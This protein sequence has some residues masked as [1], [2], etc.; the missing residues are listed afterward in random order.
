MNGQVAIYARV[1][2]EKQAE[3]HTIDSQLAAVRERVAADG[4]ELLEELQF[5]DNGYSG[6]TLIRPGLERLRD[7]AA[8]GAF[9]RL[10]VHSP[11]RLARKYAYQILLVDELRRVGV[12]VVFLNHALGR[13]PEDELLLQVQGMMAEYERA[14]IMERSRRGRRHAALRGSVNALVG[15]PYGY[16]Y[17]G[18]HQG[19]GEASVEVLEDEARVVRQ[20][21]TWV[22]RDRIPLQQV[23]VRLVEA[24]IPTRSGKKW[25]RPGTVARMLRN[26]AY[27]GAAVFGKT[28]SGPQRPRLR[29]Y[30]GHPAQAR[31]PYSSYAVPEDKWIRVPVPVL[32]DTDLFTAVC[33]Q[34]QENRQRVRERREGARHLL[35]GL[36]VCM[37]C[38][39]A[40]TGSKSIHQGQ[41]YV[42]YLCAGTRSVPAGEQR[43]CDNRPVRADTLEAIVWR[44]IRDLLGDPRRLEQ[45]YL[46][47]LQSSDRVL[48]GHDPTRLDAQ[49]KKLR[50]GIARMIDGYADG[51]IEKREFEPRIKKAKE[52]LASIEAQVEQR[53]DEV[54]LK[55]QLQLVIGKL[56]DFAARVRAGLETADWSTRRDL[57]RALIKRIDIDKE[58]I[59][60]VFRVSP[61]TFAPGIG[62][63]FSR[64]CHWSRRSDW[65][66]MS[67]R[68]GP[69]RAAF[70]LE[71]FLMAISSRIDLIRER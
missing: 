55:N 20:I 52:R 12:E 44:E 31:Y 58:Q 51:L 27:I 16:R 69:V 35:Q 37:R 5:I 60:V 30:R 63:P 46:R 24:G 7:A 49:A 54:S 48:D 47:R 42:Y 6:T 11:D 53:A 33:E 28:Q 18:K 36:V 26:P 64:D 40:Y 71:G 39:Y 61:E 14:K 13:S 21:F 3:S 62:E 29:V 8:M 15:V 70:A 1:S 38:G 23:C 22:G 43:D 25:W 45:E 56:E 10:Y 66:G 50:T 67:V 65:I 32:V 2:S 57:V 9:D 41:Q 4:F 68:L 19:S 17:I 59:N 34:L